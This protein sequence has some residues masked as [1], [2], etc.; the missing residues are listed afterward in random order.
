[1]GH[2][3]PLRWSYLESELSPR[4]REAAEWTAVQKERVLHVGDHL[5]ATGLEKL[6]AGKA[7]LDH[8]AIVERPP[9]QE[10]RRDLRLWGAQIDVD[11]LPGR[12][13]GRVGIGA[14]LHL[15]R[16]SRLRQVLIAEHDP[17]TVLVLE[18]EWH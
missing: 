3:S 14:H 2:R 7:R 11:R 6:R 1:M 16:P 8:L 12:V 9:G 13:A 10:D 17:R 5:S 18:H 15:Y 4:R